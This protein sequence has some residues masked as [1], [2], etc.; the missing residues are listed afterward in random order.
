M[1]SP[2]TLGITLGDINGIGP[3]VALKAAYAPGPDD[4]RLVLIGSAEPARHMA[5]RLGLPD[6]VAWNPAVGTPPQQ[7]VSLWEPVLPTPLETHPGTIDPAASLAAHCWITAAIDACLQGRLQGMVT[8]PISKE[9]FARAGLRT[10]GHTELLAERTGAAR[11]AM[12]LVGGGLRVVLATRHIPLRDVADALQ[13]K[14]VREAIEIAGEALPWLGMES[15]RI[16]V[17][18]LNP[19]AGDGGALGIEDEAIIRPVIQALSRCGL[20]IVGP[21]PADTVFYE[22]I[23]GAYD[24]VVAMYHDQGLGPLKTLAFDEGVNIT[25]G[26]PIV[27]TSPDHGTAFG[28]SGRGVAR[29]TSMVNAIHW[30]RTLALRPNPWATARNRSS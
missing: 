28:I 23:H 3:E 21:L 30:A 9:G 19:H 2:V 7:P 10:P 14:V 20:S 4:T 29:P 15:G 12:L 13:P 24:V 16:A 26:L 25:L 1:A 22:A 8:A 11:F 17:C 6:P 18:G 27:R 5:H